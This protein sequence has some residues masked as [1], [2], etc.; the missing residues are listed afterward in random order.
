MERLSRRAPPGCALAAAALVLGASGCAGSLEAGLRD[1]KLEL[2]G[3]RRAC[4]FA[5]VELLRR[6]HLDDASRERAFHRAFDL[7]FLGRPPVGAERAD[8]KLP[9]RPAAA[10]LAALPEAHGPARRQALE[11][12]AQAQPNDGE[13]LFLLAAEVQEAPDLARAEALFVRAA[14]LARANAMVQAWT[15]RFFLKAVSK[16]RQALDYYYRAYFLDPD[17]YETEFV[18]ARLA[19]MIPRSE[20]DACR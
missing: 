16:P 5:R 3:G 10:L 20:L 2:D 1:A 13:I 19:R 17:Y 9:Q 4:A 18:E 7:V 11:A 8:G 15:A 12:A 6:A 14:E